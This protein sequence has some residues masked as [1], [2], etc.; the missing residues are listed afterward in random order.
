M[1]KNCVEWSVLAG[2]RGIGSQLG[3]LPPDVF[4]RRIDIVYQ[5][6]QH[7]LGHVSRMDVQHN[8]VNLCIVPTNPIVER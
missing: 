3:Y 1:K 5:E 7:E 2:E 8:T 6:Q 4:E